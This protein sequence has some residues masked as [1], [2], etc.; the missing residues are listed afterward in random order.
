M[1]WTMEHILLLI[2]SHRV[3][4]SELVRMCFLFLSHEAMCLVNKESIVETKKTLLLKHQPN[5]I[6]IIIIII[7]IIMIMISV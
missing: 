2:A 6:Q 7:A 3:A 1:S 5:K 4:F